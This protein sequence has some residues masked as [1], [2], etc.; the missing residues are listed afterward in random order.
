MDEMVL[1]LRRVARQSGE[2]SPGP[3]STRRFAAAG[4]SAV[5]AAVGIL[6]A[7]WYV[8]D[9]LRSSGRRISD[10][11]VPLTTF[12]DSATSPALSPDGRM[13]TFIRGESTFYGPGQVYVKLLPDGEPVQLT[14]DAFDKM[15]PAF[16]PDGSRITY[17]VFRGASWDTWVVPVLGGEARLLL[18]NAEGLTWIARDDGPPRLL[19]SEV[20]GRDVQMAIV[21]ATE[22][23]AD[24]RV[25]YMP[26]ETGMAHRSRL[27]PDGTQVLIVEMSYSS[28]L[29]CRLTPFDGSS[30]GRAVG[31]QPA[32]CTDAA[33]SPDGNWMYFTANSGRGFHIWRQRYPDGMPEQIT[34]GTTE[35]EGVAFAANGRS[36]V[37]AIGTRQSTIWFHDEAGERQITSEGY[38]LSPTISHDGKRL[39]YLVRAPAVGSFTSGALWVADLET[40]QRQRLLADFL[41]QS[42]D[43]SADGGRLLFVA[44]DEDGRS[45]LW[46]ASLTGREPPR[47]LVERDALRAF[48]GAAGEVVFAGRDDSANVLFRIREDGSGLQ[49]IGPTSNLS[50]VSPDGQWAVTWVVPNGAM[51]QPLDGG[52][53]V[54][55]CT[56]CV[57]FGT[58]EGAPWPSAVGWSYDRRFFYLTLNGSV[59]AIPLDPGAT[60]P[61]I[62]PGGFVSEQDVTAKPGTRRIADASVFMGPDPSRFAFTR[63]ATQRNIYR[64]PLD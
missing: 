40:G 41:M 55:I 3:R 50:A 17:T 31:P 54:T 32:Q 43:V 44:A 51:A 28:W 33:W 64:I 8:L 30:P 6:A 42:Y 27:S 52:S 23:R 13:L 36:F 56:S 38:G 2:F 53:P 29:P 12:A 60:F 4:F 5:A 7:G 25:I 34:F 1:D 39:Y 20:T 10:E 9:G 26:P 62:P 37:T 22:S 47:R 18:E 59:F 35:E 61:A 14:H 24:R 63:V 57:Q 46:L 11:Y 58:F 21:T 19:F 48:F 49:R 15:D 16:T 45:P